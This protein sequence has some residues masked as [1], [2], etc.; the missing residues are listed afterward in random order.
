MTTKKNMPTSWTPATPT[1][2]MLQAVFATLREL[3]WRPD[4]EPKRCPP[5]LPPGK[6]PPAP[7][8]TQIEA[9]FALARELGWTN[10]SPWFMDL[11]VA[12]RRTDER[13][14]DIIMR[15]AKAIARDYPWRDGV[16][17]NMQE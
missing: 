11:V 15:T 6:K 3:G 12:V 2:E 4:T 17:Y 5:P 16:P 10:L 14:R 1:P 13:G 8:K 7:T 9:V